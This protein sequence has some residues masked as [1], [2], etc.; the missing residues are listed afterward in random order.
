VSLSGATLVPAYGR[1]YKSAAEVISAF[2]SGKDFSLASIFHGG[3]YVSRSDFS[4]GDKVFLRYS[5]LR[6]V[7][8][9]T[10]GGDL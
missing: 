6:K 10:V 9:A 1:D 2:Q 4:E 3:G 5:K 8:A 7:A